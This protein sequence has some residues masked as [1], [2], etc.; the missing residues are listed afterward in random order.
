M[1]I[2]PAFYSH[3]WLITNRLFVFIKIIFV[4]NTIFHWHIRLIQHLRP[5]G[6]NDITDITDI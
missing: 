4:R 2:C 1:P 6:N 3:I 5:G